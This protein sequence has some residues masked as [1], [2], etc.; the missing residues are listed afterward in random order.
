MSSERS[1]SSSEQNDIATWDA[2]LMEYGASPD[3]LT[4][5][6]TILRCCGITHMNFLQL[7]QLSES[8][9][10]MNRKFPGFGGSDVEIEQLEADLQAEK[11]MWQSHYLDHDDST[12]FLLISSTH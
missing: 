2:I 9:M 10:G 11:T 6:K 4:A 7:I 1:E 12:S 8:S 5:V 3:R